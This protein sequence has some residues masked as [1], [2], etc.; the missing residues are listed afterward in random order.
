MIKMISVRFG[1]FLGFLA[2]VAL[3]AFA[4]FLEYH[5]F[6]PCPLCLSQRVMMIGLVLTCFIGMLRAFKKSGNIVLCIFGLIF[7]LGGMLLAARQTW[8]QYAPVQGDGGCGVSLQYL[9]SVFPITEVIQIV[10]H[11]GAECSEVGWTILGLSLAE[12]SIVTF[13]MFFIFIILQFKRSLNK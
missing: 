12:W 9:L 5:G 13:G 4:Y 11:G 7:S 10:W 8:L 6:I 1:F 2:T 3:M